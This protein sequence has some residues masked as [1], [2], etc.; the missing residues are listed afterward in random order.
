MEL[1]DDQ[2]I[3]DY[4]KSLTKKTCPSCNFTYQSSDD[5]ASL[6]DAAK[7]VD[8]NSYNM[9]FIDVFC[10]NRFKPTN[11]G[12]KCGFQQNINWFGL[13]EFEIPDKCPKCGGKVLG[14]ALL[15]KVSIGGIVE[16]FCINCLKKF[17]Q[18]QPFQ[19]V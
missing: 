16:S 3:N 7:K 2:K 5:V 11:E 13:Y 12:T 1:S 19:R 9:L 8:K 14:T 6:I 18:S 15:M 17:S 10:E 4:E